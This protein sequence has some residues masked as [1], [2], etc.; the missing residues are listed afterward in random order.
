[1]FN[2]EL[3][4]IKKETHDVKTFRFKILGDPKIEFKPG[5]FIILHTMINKKL[6]KRSYSISSSPLE[7]RYIEITLKL[8]EG[9]EMS[10]YLHNNVKIG[11]DFKAEGPMGHFTYKEDMGGNVCLLAGGSGIA[12]MRSIML[13]C[14]E[15]KLDTKI[16]LFY[17]VERPMML[18]LEMN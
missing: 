10:D 16:V 7:K 2:I 3:V 14:T 8:I 15:K 11:E 13:Y 17:S 9:G 18:Y 6:V 5:Q 4:N 12:P 1:M